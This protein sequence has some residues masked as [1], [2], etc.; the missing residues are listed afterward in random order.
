MGDQEYW[1][2]EL[3]PKSLKVAELRKILLENDISFGGHDKKGD[4]VKL[5]KAN[6]DTIRDN[7][8]KE[9]EALP[10]GDGVLRVKKTRKKKG[11]SVFDGGK[12][13]NTEGEGMEGSVEEGPRPRKSTRIASNTSVEENSV[14]ES[15]RS[16]VGSSPFS[17]VNEF[18]KNGNSRKR[19]NYDRDDEDDIEEQSSPRKFQKKRN[20]KG[21]L[22]KVKKEE[23]GDYSERSS[24][25]SPIA[26]KLQSKRTPVKGEHRS[27]VIHK[28]ETSS[29]ESLSTTSTPTQKKVLVFDK[30]SDGKIEAH[31]FT[32][33]MRKQFAPDLSKLKVSPEFQLKLA[34]LQKSKKGAPEDSEKIASTDTEDASTDTTPP[35]T[36]TNQHITPKASKKVSEQQSLRKVATNPTVRRTKTA[37]NVGKQS[38]TTSTP[39]KQLNGKDHNGKAEKQTAKKKKK[40]EELLTSSE[41]GSE[42]K[43]HEPCQKVED[44]IEK[45]DSDVLADFESSK[46]NKFMSYMGH[47]LLK[48]FTFLLIVIPILFG[49][50]Y[51]EQRVLVGYCGHEINSPTFTNTEQYPFLEHLDTTLQ[52][53]KPSCL[54][55]PENAIC[56]PYMKIK[57]KPDYAVTSSVFSLYGLFPVSEYCAKDSKR[58]RLVSEVVHKSLELLRTKN[59]RIQCGECED[60][61]MSGISEDELYQIFFESKAPWIN[62][63]EFKDIWTQV[64]KDL[65]AESDIVCRQVSI[66]QSIFF[67][68]SMERI[69]L[70]HF[71]QVPGRK[72]LIQ[73]YSDNIF[74][75]NDI[76]E[77]E[78]HFQFTEQKEYFRSVSKKYIGIRCQFER[79]VYRTY[80]RFTLIFWSVII[81]M[82]LLQLLK[83]KLQRRFKEQELVEQL[84]SQVIEK[85]K[86]V[87]QTKSSDEP[88][89]LSTVQLRDVLL[90]DVVDLKYKNQL[91]NKVVHILESSN[92][93]V[94]SML[95][96]VH[97][98]IMKCWEWVG[99]FE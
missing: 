61:T 80:Q 2:Q 73:I 27:L 94:K 50:W 48:I 28:F 52:K 14:S 38:A 69:M 97:G 32:Q 31:D 89:F 41:Q 44:L 33:P 51:R 22:K 45:P 57:C 12:V 83:I 87:A 92:T 56:Y 46:L 13:S 93:N 95:M 99:P 74:E 17:D 77:Q 40:T 15:V 76:Q 79:Q 86:C 42:H 35:A 25:R 88:K 18:Q 49:L 10:S 54:P 71:L 62:E 58:E 30:E 29:D 90:V 20:T 81:M 21:P 43:T 60:D 16:A 39:K 82:I 8:I 5:F 68:N 96:E 24:V 91:W 26:T 78:R 11:A 67:P 66:N 34:T 23:S 98:E 19:K 64:V 63:E 84:K 36:R 72:A 85:L 53:F 59:A 75:A 3:D 55:C 70:T 7:V 65:R 47:S 6:M 9:R 4:L 1:D 37:A